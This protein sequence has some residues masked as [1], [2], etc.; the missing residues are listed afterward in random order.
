ME[1]K[2]RIKALGLTQREFAGML[3]KT[4][5]TLARQLHGLQGMKAGPDIHNYLA[6]LEMLRSNGLWED[7]MKVA[8]IHP[9]TL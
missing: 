3:G 8:K 6:A 1:L 2:D 9:K 5:P 7:F 4:Q